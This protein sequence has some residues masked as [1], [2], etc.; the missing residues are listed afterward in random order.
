MPRSPRPVENPPQTLPLELYWKQSKRWKNS[1]PEILANYDAE[2]ITVYIEVSKVIAEA[3]VQQQHGFRVGH[4]PIRV[5]TSFIPMQAFTEWNTKFD[6]VYKLDYQK[7]I[8]A[9]RRHQMKPS[10]LIYNMNKTDHRREQRHTLAV[11]VKR[12][13]FDHWLE[14]AQ[15]MD[16]SKYVWCHNMN[17]VGDEF[18]NTES[19]NGWNFMEGWWRYN[20]VEEPDVAYRW[21]N[22]VYPCLPL[23]GSSPQQRLARKVLQLR[24]HGNVAIDLDAPGGSLGVEDITPFVNEMRPRLTHSQMVPDLWSPSESIYP[25]TH[26]KL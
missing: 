26:L 21:V 15:S 2:S 17:D 12:K 14:L 5:Y 3:A 25:F 9:I 22:D 10:R 6:P 20:K 8:L 1:G 11:C 4:E 7:K 18:H 24:L 19:F 23:D 16:D 13:V